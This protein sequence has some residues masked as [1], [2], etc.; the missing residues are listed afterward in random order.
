MGGRSAEPIVPCGEIL[1]SHGQRYLETLSHGLLET[2]SVEESATFIKNLATRV[3][4]LSQGPMS[5]TADPAETP[6]SA[7]ASQVH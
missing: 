1:P 2:V 3:Q 4:V 5:A 6:S 7:S